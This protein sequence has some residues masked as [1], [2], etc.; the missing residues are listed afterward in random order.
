MGA[1]S[2]IW[3]LTSQVKLNSHEGMLLSFASDVKS[4]IT[5]VAID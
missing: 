2:V 5:R 4:H 3:D 1:T